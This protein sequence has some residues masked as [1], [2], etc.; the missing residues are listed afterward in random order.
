MLCP[1]PS[2]KGF[3]SESHINYKSSRPSHCIYFLFAVFLAYCSNLL[4]RSRSPILFV[5]S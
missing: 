1:S 2:L 3:S 4:A 5:S